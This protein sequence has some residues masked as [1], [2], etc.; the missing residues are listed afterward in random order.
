MNFWGESTSSYAIAGDHKEFLIT[1]LK[2][3]R[4]IGEITQRDNLLP[5]VGSVFEAED[6]VMAPFSPSGLA[7]DLILSTLHTSEAIAGLLIREIACRIEVNL[8]VS[9][10]YTLYRAHMESS[11]KALWLMRPTSARARMRN[12]LRLWCGE[13]EHFN[14]FTE[15]W[16]R[17]LPAREPRS[18]DELLT[19][20]QAAGIDPGGKTALKAWP[21]P[22][23]TSVLRQI[24]Q[25][26]GNRIMTWFN[27]WQLCS[28]FAH[29]KRWANLAFS[30]LFPS[31]AD[32]AVGRADLTGQR[33]SSAVLATI[34]FEAGTL[35]DT[36]CKR[37][38]QLATTSDPSWDSLLP[39]QEA[40]EP[41]L[42]LRRRTRSDGSEEALPNDAICRAAG[43]APSVRSQP[44][45][46][47]PG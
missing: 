16:K 11:A 31:R 46:A 9:G 41:P 3:E 47:G 26:H 23:S 42:W 29:G 18:Y 37:Y 28:G 24:E 7:R 4:E 17:T 8:P 1:R 13:V 15:E 39:W 22:G 34:A 10:A 32:D 6:R 25:F 36:A 12:A 5:R 40:T 14:D 30:E 20:A 35:L 38:A 2:R 33:G 43:P 19:A 21:S 44:R 45:N 27:A